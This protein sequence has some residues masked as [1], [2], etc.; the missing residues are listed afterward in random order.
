[1]IIGTT[2]G[3]TS[4]LFNYL[5]QH[6]QIARS[7]PKEIY[8]TWT[9]ITKKASHITR[10]NINS[11]YHEHS[12]SEPM[13]PEIREVLSDYFRPHNSRLFDLIGKEFDWNG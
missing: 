1:M 3:G 2:K 12:Y 8:S 4:S 7:S 6:P 13:K 10:P 5:R 11:R 9:A